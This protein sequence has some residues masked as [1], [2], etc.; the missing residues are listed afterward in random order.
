MNKQFLF[1]IVSRMLVMT[2][3]DDVVPRHTQ[4]RFKPVDTEFY[5]RLEPFQR[6]FRMMLEIPLCPVIPLFRKLM[7]FSFSLFHIIVGVTIQGYDGK[8]NS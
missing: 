8:N 6:I 5:R 1:R 7:D 4:V 2:E 3:H